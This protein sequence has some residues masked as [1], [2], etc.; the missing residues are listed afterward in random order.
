MQHDPEAEERGSETLSLGDL[1]RELSRLRR[2]LLKHGHAQELFQDRVEAAMAGLATRLETSARRD[3]RRPPPADKALSAAQLRSLIE[4]GQAARN[5]KNLAASGSPARQAGDDTPR[6]VREGLDL[7]EIRVSNLQRSF[8]LEPIPARG[9]QFDDRLHRAQA[10]CR[11]P[12]LP[13]GQVVEEVQPGYL[14]DGEV[15]RPA[16]V[17]VNKLA[18]GPAGPQDQQDEKE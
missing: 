4:L 14:M 2:A 1:S 10:V 15:K 6:S 3:D 5:L 8:G 12:D 17:V 11:R 18:A 16:S 9:R 7:L 13:D